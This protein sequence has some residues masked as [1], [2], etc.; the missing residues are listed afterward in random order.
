MTFTQTDVN[1]LPASFV[2]GLTEVTAVGADHFMIF[3]ATDSALKKSLVSDVLESATSI[4]TSADAT[5][6]TIDSSENVTFTNNVTINSGQL[7]AGG[8]AYPTSDGTNGQVLTTDGSGTL[9]FSTVSGTTINNNAD[10]RIITGSGTANTLNGESGL[11]YDGSTLDVTG[12]V[13]ADGLTT[14]GTFTST[15]I[16]DNA[17]GTAIL[18]ESDRNVG[19]NATSLAS[20]SGYGTLTINGSSGGQIAFHT[21]ETGKQYIYSTSTDLNI[22]NS[23]AG[24][25][26]FSTNNLE[27]ARI[28]SAGNFGI[29]IT[30]PSTRT[31]IYS[32]ANSTPLIVESTANTYVGIKN[33]TQT[34]YIGAVTSNMIFENN[35]SERM[36]IDG[37]GNITAPNQPSFLCYPPSTFTAS[38]GSNKYI[39]TSESFDKGGNYNTTNGRFTAPVSGRYLFTAVLAMVSSTT[40]LT[41][42]GI[43]FRVNTSGNIYY[44]GWDH[45]PSDSTYACNSSSVILELSANDYVEI[46]IETGLAHGVYGAP[47][48]SNTRWSGHLLS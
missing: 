7:T 32:S 16:D 39:F 28:D 18:I 46:Y 25:L 11:T 22:L 21:G 48:G 24:N 4:S 31:H 29:G 9:S 35:G 17:T 14:T 34:A 6:I 5:A 43:G 20:T 3:D 36:R 10:N 42:Y 47:D 38:A 44:G 13:T 15:G 30:N 41:Y 8:L 27:R 26:I 2:S 45:K 19:I 23:A 40:A 1:T 37:S 33:T 12:T